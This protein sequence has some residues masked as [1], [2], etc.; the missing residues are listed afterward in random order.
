MP[1][2]SSGRPWRFDPEQAIAPAQ[3]LFH[4]HGYDTV[5]VADG[6]EALGINTPSVYAASQGLS[7]E[8]AG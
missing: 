3:E 4:A 2:T 1:A 5:R 7:I 6:T 8:R